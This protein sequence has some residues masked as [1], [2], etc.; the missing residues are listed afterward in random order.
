MPGKAR[1]RPHLMLVAG[2]ASVGLALVGCSRSTDLAQPGG[3]QGAAANQPGAAASTSTGTPAPPATL[4]ANVRPAASDVP[5]DTAVVVKAANGTL[6]TV[7]FTAADGTAI[8]GAFDA[9]RTTWTAAELLDPGVQYTL[10]SQAVNADGK[11]TSST[12][13]FTTSDL[14]LDQQTYPSVTPLAGKTMGIAM[15]VVVTFDIPVTDRAAFEKR[16]SVTSVPAQV[17]SWHW[18]S[19]HEVHWRPRTYWEAGTKVSVDLALNGVNAGNGIYGQVDRHIHFS[20]GEAVL[21]KANV[22]TER[23][24][25][26]VAGKVVRT[27]KI[28]GGKPGFETRG[29]T[30]VISE[31]YL[32]KRMN[33][34]TVGIDPN[35]PNGYNIANVRYA[36]RVTNSGEFLHAAPWS[37]RAQ[38]HYN[39]SHGCVGMSTPNAAWVFHRAQIGTPVEV[40]GT[41]RP[42]EPQNGWTDWNQSWAQYQA[43]S[44]LG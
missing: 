14:T 30:K 6:K 4:T 25:V 38:G 28:T 35:G 44:A 2:V 18:V 1:R 5:V 31:K 43:A 16:M 39:I 17:G 42:L 32:S 29:G 34:A 26:L 27:I 8:R 11:A 20:I 36:M 24:Q 10:H 40:S 13:A 21:I 19:G 3:V 23:M 7:A 15:P 37:I 22:S 33:S 12:R 9:A 41:K